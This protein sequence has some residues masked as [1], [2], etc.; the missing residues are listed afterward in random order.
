MKEHPLMWWPFLGSAEDARP[1]VDTAPRP[2]GRT[3]LGSDTTIAVSCDLKYTP[4]HG[5]G[6]YFSICLADLTNAVKGELDR[7]D[8]ISQEE[9][10]TVYFGP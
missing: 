1:A 3:T 6:S 2:V 9:G 5:F 7:A 8:P 4:S 10:R